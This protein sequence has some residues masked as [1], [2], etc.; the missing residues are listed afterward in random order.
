MLILPAARRRGTTLVFV[1]MALI[2]ALALAVV[3]LSRAGR[4]N[5][6][7][8]QPAPEATVAV[9][10]TISAGDELTSDTG[11]TP[12]AVQPQV[13]PPPPPLAVTPDARDLPPEG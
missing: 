10:T 2:A 7:Q 5:A 8:Q 3:F 12:A 9:P 11:D 6:D 1:L 13:M 4:N